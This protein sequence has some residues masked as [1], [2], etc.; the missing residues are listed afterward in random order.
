M[1]NVILI[2]ESHEQARIEAEEK[3]VNDRMI[4]PESLKTDI[5]YMADL[6]KESSPGQVSKNEKNLDPTL[7]V[8]DLKANFHKLPREGQNSVLRQLDNIRARNLKAKKQEAFERLP[9]DIKAGVGMPKEN[10]KML[11]VDQRTALLKKLDDIVK[12]ERNREKER[13]VA[14]AVK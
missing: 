12:I 2:D 9:E 3:Y 10:L 11:K 6:L 5:K 8:A 13:I 1:K 14:E 4:D 7:K